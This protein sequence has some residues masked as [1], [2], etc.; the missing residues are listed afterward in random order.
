MQIKL[1]EELGNFSSRQ[2]DSK[3]CD[4]PDE[5][6]SIEALVRTAGYASPKAMLNDNSMWSMTLREVVTFLVEQIEKEAAR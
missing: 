2:L 6:S 1:N 5:W 3:M 4:L